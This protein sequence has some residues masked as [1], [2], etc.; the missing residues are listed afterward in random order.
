MIFSALSAVLYT[1]VVLLRARSSPYLVQKKTERILRKKLLG[2]GPV[3]SYAGWYKS[4]AD[5]NEQYKYC[6]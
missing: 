3:P 6:T 5:R 1:G 4:R 2:V